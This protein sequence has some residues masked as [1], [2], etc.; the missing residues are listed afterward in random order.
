MP[1]D[2]KELS[3]AIEV[4]EDWFVKGKNQHHAVIING[5]AYFGMDEKSIHNALL[6]TEYDNKTR[7]FIA[8]DTFQYQ[9][10]FTRCPPWEPEDK[11][12]I[13]TVRET[14]LLNYRAWLERRG[15]KIN[16]KD[17]DDILF[18]LA[19][20]NEK[21]PPKEYLEK[22][23]WDGI[24]RADN[25][26]VNACDAQDDPDYLA[27]VGSKMLIASVKRIFEPGAKFDL[28][29]I[30]EG[31]QGWKKSSI[32]EAL[33]TI[34]GVR[35]FLDEPIRI[36][37][38]DGLMKLQGKLFFEMAEL[39]TLQKG[40]ETEE[41]KAFITRRADSYREPYK[42]KVI[43]RLRRFI[44]GGTTNPMGGYLTDAT[45]NRRYLPVECGK[46][47][48]IEW[49]ELNKEQLWA[50]AVHRYYAGERIW[51]EG[52]EL[53]L[54]EIEQRKRY[55][56]AVNH[57]SILK[58]IK[59]VETARLAE[60][61]N[62][63]SI[64]DVAIAAGADKLEKITPL[65]NNQIKETLTFYGYVTCRPREVVAGDETRGEKWQHE[66]FK[67]KRNDGK[68]VQKRNEFCTAEIIEF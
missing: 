21:N 1:D 7:D 49:F 67:K 12:T 54:A 40:G 41:M 68:L 34:R 42:R 61:Y 50:E 32:W 62:Y 37:D 51:L 45:G 2:K 29:P 64:E 26:L 33:A 66:R 15:I 28:V 36:T 31:K 24:K 23:K 57:D 53:K 18:S 52:H 4:S 6:V 20:R 39:A 13:H 19:Q 35:Y 47:F 38:K 11:F 9:V 14:D 48:D 56:Q 10:Y 65:L 27:L 17:A 30:F 25:W 16:A 8:F 59:K 60:G 44:I 3:V 46:E 55:K 5:K 22:L 43:E 63:F 58:A